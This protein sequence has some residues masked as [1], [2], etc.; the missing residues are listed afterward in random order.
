MAAVN[1]PDVQERL[2]EKG[3][4]EKIA[5]TPAEFAAVIAREIPQYARIVKITGAKAE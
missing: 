4:L 3:G 2:F 1:M 5:N